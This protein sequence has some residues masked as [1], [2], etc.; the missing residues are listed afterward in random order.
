MPGEQPKPGAA[1]HSR[2]MDWAP[3]FRNSAW[4]PEWVCRRCNSG[5]G[6]AETQ[7][8]NHGAR[9]L[10]QIHGPQTHVLDL[11]SSN[12]GFACVHYGDIVTCGHTNQTAFRDPT[13]RGISPHSPDA[14]GHCRREVAESELRPCAHCNLRVR[15][16]CPRPCASDEPED[17][18]GGSLAACGYCGLQMRRETI[19]QCRLCGAPE[20]RDCP[21]TCVASS[22]DDGWDQD[23]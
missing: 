13:L 4:N 21:H 15:R 7:H 11:H 6:A 1:A 5:I 19:R 18:Q 23:R 22:D 10:C 14:C 16:S 2:E 20:C 17:E 9:Q 3:Y 8:G 12:R